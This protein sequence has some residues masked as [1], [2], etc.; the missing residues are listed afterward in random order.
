MDQKLYQK[1]F[2][3]IIFLTLIAISFLII[4]PFLTALLTGIVF[5]YIF[6]PLYKTIL[7]RIPNKN[8]SA[9]IASLLVILLI[10][11]PLFFVLNT[12]SQEAYA[13]YILSRQ[14]SSNV[15]LLSSECQPADKSACKLMQYFAVKANEPQIKYYLDTAIKDVTVKITQNIS[16]I[17]ISIPVFMI[18]M[19]IALFV[20]FFLFRDGKLLINKI[21]RLMPLKD[22]HRKRVFEKLSEMTYAVIYGSIIIA[23]IQGAL[24]GI[25]FFIFGLPTPLLWGMV[26]VFASFIPYVGSSIIWFPASLLLIFNGYGDPTLVIKGVFLMIYG[27][28]VVGTMDNI[29][30]P[31]IIGDKS[32]LH[33]VLVLLG[34]VGGLQLLGFMGVI[35]GPILLALLVAFVNIYE[36][37]NQ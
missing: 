23:I 7:K 9:F 11:M 33:P 28:F 36:E 2:F 24:G 32:G 12:I 16:S 14:K 22:K 1:A 34:V 27:V 19:F 25:G 26:M 4:K 18:H 30:K 29:L 37:E 20:M 3:S 13:T 17:L 15:Q 8:A 21:E 31:K 6:Y 5:S 35:I 10:T